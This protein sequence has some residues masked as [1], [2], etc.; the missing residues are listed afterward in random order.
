M[1]ESREF[2][3]IAQYTVQAS[4]PSGTIVKVQF[5]IDP[6]VGFEDSITVPKGRILRIKDVYTTGTPSVDALITFYKND[7]EVIGSTDPLSTQLVSNNTRN[8]IKP[9]DVEEFGKLTAKATTLATGGASATT[10]T[11]YIRAEL[12]PAKPKAKAKGLGA[13][14]RARLG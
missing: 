2:T 10:D 1:S 7:E 5:Q 3:I 6:A 11:F 8:K 9:F 13:L 4:A 14:L 12:I